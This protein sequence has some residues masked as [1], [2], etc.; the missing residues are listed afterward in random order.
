MGAFENKL[1][2]CAEVEISVTCRDDQRAVFS[3]FTLLQLTQSAYD[4]PPLQA[5]ADDLPYSP[6]MCLAACTAQHAM[7]QV[8]LQCC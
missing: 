6:R 7:E 5:T 2:H 1:A 4:V 8:Y 3:A